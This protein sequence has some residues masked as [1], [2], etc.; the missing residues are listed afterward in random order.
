VDIKV[1]EG[2][3]SSRRHTPLVVMDHTAVRV[4]DGIGEAVFALD[5]RGRCSYANQAALRLLDVPDLD[6]L[7][8]RHM[9]DVLHGQMEGQPEAHG[10]EDCPMT[11]ALTRGSVT[12]ISHATFRRADGSVVEVEC[13]AYP[14]ASADE[15][16]GAAVTCVDVSGYQRARD[17]DLFR[18]VLLDAQTE[19][20]ID[21]IL[22]VSKDTKMLSFNRRFIDLWGVPKHIVESRSDE[23]AISWVLQKVSDP[24]AFGSKV[25]YLYEHPDEES[26]DLIALK[27]GRTFDRYSAPVRSR[28]GVYYGRVW[29]F[30]DVSDLKDAEA[31]LARLY[32]EARQAV[33]MRDDFLSIASHELRTPLTSLQLQAQSLLRRLG[34]PESKDV[35]AWV[36]ERARGV[37]DLVTRL[38]SLIEN[39]LDISRITSGRLRLDP[40]DFDLAA[41]VRVVVARHEEQLAEAG[42]VVTLRADGPVIGHWDKFRMEQIV[43]NLLSNAVKYGQGQPVEVIVD[44]D[45]EQA[46]IVV[47]DGGIGIDPV[48]RQR[49]FQRFERAVSS[50]HYSGFG[51]G[52]WIVAEIVKAMAGTIAVTG[53]VGQG[54]T[55]VVTLPLREVALPQPAGEGD[56]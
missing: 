17:E 42:C 28:E 26:R 55:F 10:R 32:E 5:L 23:L 39:L 52:L 20:S 4:L 25:A 38:S 15:V 29:F 1:K 41:L 18:R 34:K 47:R 56:R 12:H 19:A 48:D 7:L 22:V 45:G 13:R 51:L 35:P 21:G 2:G 9:H 53:A 43:T 11:R 46:R 27:D 37:Q 3:K 44:A 36:N 33:R 6:Q 50:S 16:V 31:E 24:Q 54:S 30:R 8:G 49:I 14:L 40:E